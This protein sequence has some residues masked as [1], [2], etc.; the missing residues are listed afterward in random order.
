MPRSYPYVSE[1]TAK[2]QRIAVCWISKGKKFI[3]DIRQTCELK[4]KYGNRHFWCRGYYGDHQRRS[5]NQNASRAALAAG[6]SELPV[7]R[8]KLCRLEHD[9][10]ISD[11][12]AYADR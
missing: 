4:Y 1:H 6:A 12:K 11:E 2:Y 5:V 9:C 3:D 10:T 8:H 7:V